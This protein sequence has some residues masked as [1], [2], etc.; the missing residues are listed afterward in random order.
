M[1]E[2]VAHVVTRMNRLM[3]Q[4]RDG[5]KSAAKPRPIDIRETI[6]RVVMVKREYCAAIEV[7]SGPPLLA[8]THEEQ[9]ERVIGHIVQNAIEASSENGHPV[10]LRAHAE[11]EY[12]VIEVV[13]RGVGM[14]EEFIRERLFRPFQTTKPQGMGIGM[15]ESFQYVSAIGGRI[16]VESVASA[17]TRFRL[18]L[19]A[20]GSGPPSDPFRAKV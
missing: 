11:G 1:L 15:N 5:A 9:I 3:L 12:V 18:W 8:L 13:D 6:N 20:A 17:G 16:E 2:T 7:E 19:R 4:L 10:T 14:T